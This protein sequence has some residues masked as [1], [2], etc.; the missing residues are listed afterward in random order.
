MEYVIAIDGGG[1]SC[2][3]A[4]AD[5]D[6]RIVGRGEHGAA[7]VSTDLPAAIDNIA[8]AAGK[9]LADAGIA[10]VQLADLPALLGLAGFNVDEDTRST[11]ARLPFARC[12]FEDDVV[13][14]LQS[15]LGDTDG[16]VAVLGTGS[17]YMARSGD[18]I[19][20]RGGWGFMVGDQASGAWLGRAVLRETLL[21]HDRLR[22]H[23]PLSQAVLD[24]FGGD[25]ATLVRFAQQAKPGSFARF[26]PMVFD[27]ADNNDVIARDLVDDA[28]AHIDAVLETLVWPKCPQLCLTGGLAKFYYGRI[29]ERFRAMLREPQ[30]ETLAGAV[31]LAVRAFHPTPVG[32]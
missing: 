28:V 10:D 11:A 1:T 23:T 30:A 14:A 5:A 15:A 21:A 8:A 29:G 22:A 20:K 17:V 13:I 6:G 4:V 27:H 18:T 31:Q 16:V 25:P 9:A 24:E 26:A 3:A 2:R 19:T 32:S 7:N 12:V